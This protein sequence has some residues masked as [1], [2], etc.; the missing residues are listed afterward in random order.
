[1]KFYNIHDILKIGIEN[2][3]LDKSL[4]YF[5]TEELDNPDL[6]IKVNEFDTNL[7]NYNRLGR[8]YLREDEVIEKRKF[9]S[10]QLKNFLGRTELNVTSGYVRLRP[11]PT[12]VGN[13]IGLKLLTKNHAF[14][15]SACVS[16]NGE[17]YL[18]CAWQGTGKT[19]VSLKLVKD[20]SFS[21]LSDDMTIIN[22]HGQAYCFP[23]NVKL[24]LSHT[25]EFELGNKAKLK[26]LIGKFIQGIPIINRRLEII[27]SVPV[28]EIIKNAKIEKQCKIRKVIM[29]QRAADEGITEIDMGIAIKR[30]AL[31]NLWERNYWIDHLFIAYAYSD[32]EFDLQKLEDKEQNILNSALKEASCYQVKFREYAYSN[33]EKFLKA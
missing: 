9:G 8:Y 31:L 12:L 32:Q 11:I 29:L 18:I 23:A 6:I 19:M 13:I 4:S 14:I 5:S 24:S 27:H 7:S 17:G 30:L 15:H 2:L 26:L 1:V 16:R 22:D 20:D 33:I 10:I 28:T 25:R 21:F 3:D